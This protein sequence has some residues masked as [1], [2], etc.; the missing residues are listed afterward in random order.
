MSWPAERTV[1][2]PFDGLRFVDPAT[3]QMI[4]AWVQR[5]PRL[6]IPFTPLRVPLCR[7]RVA[8]IT[9]AAVALRTDTPFDEEGERKN[10]WWGDPS[11]RFIPDGTRTEEIDVHHLHINRAAARADLN[12]VLPLDRL[13]ELVQ[14][15]VVGASAR[16]H[17][18]FQG[19]LLRPEEM[20][21]TS[22]PQM[23]GR[24][25]AEEVDAALLVPA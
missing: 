22:V 25:K 7:A 14:Q 3:S 11:C 1:G 2:T 24:M 17:C 23:L 15:G 13:H 20:L 18:S 4:K 21:A 6:D 19:Y 5:E 10:P 12:C 8:L 9:S 16:T